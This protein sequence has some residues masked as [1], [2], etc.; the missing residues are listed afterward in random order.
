[1]TKAL[2]TCIVA[3]SFTSAA[4]AELIQHTDQIAE[5]R[6]TGTSYELGK[7]VGEVAKDQILDCINR[8]D[9]TLGIMLPGLSVSSL[10]ETFEKNDVYGQLRKCS[11]DAAAYI[12]GLSESLDRAPNLLLVVG[13]S[14]EAIL[15]SQSKG[16]IGFLQTEKPV[17]SQGP[18]PMYGHGRN[19]S[20]W[21][22]LG[23]SQFRLHGDQLHRSNNA[24]PHG[25]NG[26]NP[27]HPDMGGPNTL[28][29]YFKGW[30]G[31]TDEHH[32]R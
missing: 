24:E 29:R 5:V 13:M 14:D 28:R 2:I 30:S 23:C 10:S 4:N 25:Y 32:G 19:R 3:A 1:M 9:R 12:K 20:E 7:H 16:G 27:C 11:P 8:F 18:R 31:H 26:Q 22:G 6:F 15:E 21:Q 17:R